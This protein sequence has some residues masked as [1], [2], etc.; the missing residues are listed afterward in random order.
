MEMLKKALQGHW[1]GHPLHPALVHLPTGLLPASVLFDLLSY[2][3]GGWPE[4]VRLSWLAILVA[5]VVVLLAVPTGI[6]DWWEVKKENPAHQLGLYHLVGNVVVTVLFLGSLVWR[7]GSLDAMSVPAGPLVLSIA[8]V[9]VLFVAG[10][11]GGLMVYEHGV[12]VAR[13]SKKRWRKV[14]EQGRANLPEEGD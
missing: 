7:W 1:F 8:G 2:W 11:L 9:L 13:M 14:A 12:S 10:Y 6:A 3:G 5:L 4:M